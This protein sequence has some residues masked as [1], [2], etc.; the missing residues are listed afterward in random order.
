MLKPALLALWERNYRWPMDSPHKGFVRREAFPCNTV[1]TDRCRCGESF[2]SKIRGNTIWL[3]RQW[4]WNDRPDKWSLWH[5]SHLTTF[6]AVVQYIPRNMHT[7][8][9]L[10]CFV[11]VIYWL[12]FPYPS[13]LLHWHC[14]N[15]TIAPVPAK[16]PWWIW[17]NT[18]CEFIMNDCITT[19]K[20]STT[21]PCAYFL[22][23][24][25]RKNLTRSKEQRKLTCWTKKKHSD[26]LSIESSHCN[27][28][29]Y[30]N[31]IMSTMAS[32]ITSLTIV[33]STVHSGVDQRKH[34][35]SASLA[36][37]RGILQWPVNSPHKGPVTRKMFLFDDVIMRG[38][39]FG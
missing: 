1:I 19:T 14:G 32:Q 27:A 39:L 23:Y 28:F 4:H 8:F 10:L 20:Q 38:K 30:N 13:G 7:V 12:I 24:T 3:I 22:G 9:A 37:V 33:Y 17:I 36:F 16:Q 6:S 11:V 5:F 26:T 2:H 21:K 34:Q 15:L 35:S 18:S 31:V 29:Y 25:V